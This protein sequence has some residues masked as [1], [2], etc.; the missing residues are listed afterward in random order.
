M[1][2]GI[3]NRTTPAGAPE[4][5][6]D[7]IEFTVSQYCDPAVAPNER[8]K[9]FTARILAASALSDAKQAEIRSQLQAP[10]ATTKKGGAR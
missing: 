3:P 4:W 9:W 5:L 6:A 8:W 10:R 1:I 2:A 7:L